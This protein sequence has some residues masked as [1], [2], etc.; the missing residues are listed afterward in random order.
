MYKF[1][2]L[3]KK[4]TDERMLE[5]HGKQKKINAVFIT[6]KHGMSKLAILCKKCNKD[7]IMVS[8]KDKCCVHHIETWHVQISFSM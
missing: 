6:S 3:C 5:Y 1:V 8:K 2:I 4:N 7:N